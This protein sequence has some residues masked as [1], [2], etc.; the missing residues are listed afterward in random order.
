MGVDLDTAARDILRA[1]D[2]G[3]FTVPTARLYPYQ[4]NW[5]SAFAALGFAEFDLDR[6]WREL[7]TLV[8]G[9]WPNGMIPHIIFRRDDPDYFPGPP[10][11]NTGREPPTSGYT[12]PPVLATVMRALYE[13]DP[14]CLLYTSPSPRD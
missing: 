2:R 7:E 4:W 14:V 1:N 8:E 9:Q 3:G 10:V 13:R 11:W 12:Q 6:A 5:D